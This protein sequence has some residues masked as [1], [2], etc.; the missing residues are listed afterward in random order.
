MII[1]NGDLLPKT[2]LQLRGIAVANYNMGC[3]INIAAAIRIM[4][5]YELA[6]LTIQEHTP[7]NRTLSEVEITSIQ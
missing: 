1:N 7:W 3:N 4:V 5:Q 6:I 2:F